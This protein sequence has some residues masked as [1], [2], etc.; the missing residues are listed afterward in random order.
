[1]IKDIAKNIPN[2]DE[3][4]FA[5][6]NDQNNN[7]NNMDNNLNKDEYNSDED[8]M[9]NISSIAI[10]NNVSNKNLNNMNL[11]ADDIFH[12]DDFDEP[13][14]NMDDH[15]NNESIQIDMQQAQS[16]DNDVLPLNDKQILDN[17][18]NV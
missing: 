8:V 17:I 7:V 12:N 18:N 1:N 2:I 3:I 11:R 9:M 14:G 4:E 5:T 6:R 10:D 13:I 16:L 15:Y